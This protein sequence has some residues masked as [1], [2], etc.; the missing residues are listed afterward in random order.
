MGRM[1]EAAGGVENGACRNLGVRDPKCAL[2]HAV[3][4]HP[5]DLIDQAILVALHDL[6]GFTGQRQIGRKHLGIVAKPLVLDRKHRAQPAFQP[7]GGRAGRLGNLQKWGAGTVEPAF[8]DGLAQ[9]GFAGEMAV[10][11]A[12]A[13]IERPGHIDH[14]GL[15]E[16]VTAQN[17]L[18]NLQNPLGGQN[19]DFVHWRTFETTRRVVIRSP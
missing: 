17:V 11:A 10:D 16:P 6:A 7:F 1:M 3:R 15:G 12:V 18:G 19:H 8:G 9:R 13:N 4:E 5:C 14:S 2:L